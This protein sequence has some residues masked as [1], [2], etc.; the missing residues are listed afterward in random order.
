MSVF[1][2]IVVDTSPKM[3]TVPGRICL[4]FECL[5][6]LEKGKSRC[7]SQSGQWAVL[8]GLRVVGAGGL[9]VVVLVCFGWGMKIGV[10]QASACHLSLAEMRD[11]ADADADSDESFPRDMINDNNWLGQ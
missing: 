8:S 6:G 10:F 11:D 3:T 4:A 1:A 2:H 9:P 5:E 7:A